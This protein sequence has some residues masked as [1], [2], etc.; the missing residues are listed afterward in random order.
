MKIQQAS[1]LISAKKYKKALIL[2]KKINS[3]K[4]QQTYSSL[5]LEG[6]CLI[7]EKKYQMAE[8]LLKQSLNMA[9]S[10]EE[11]CNTLLNLRTVCYLQEK[12]EDACTYIAELLTI[13]PSSKYAE[14]RLQLCQIAVE[15]E[16]YNAVIGFSSKL[17]G[18]DE[19]AHSAQVITVFAYAKLDK[20]DKILPLFIKIKRDINK[21]RPAQIIQLLESFS[22]TKQPTLLKELIELTSS[23][24]GHEEWFK[25]QRNIHLCESDVLKVNSPITEQPAFSI[26]KNVKIQ[27]HKRI[28]GQS[29]STIKVIE[30]LVS[31]LEEMGAK[32]HK[33]ICFV[34]C[35]GNLSIINNASVGISVPIKQIQVPLKCMPLLCDF[36]FSISE[37]QINAY[38]VK[39][40]KNLSSVP[41]MEVMIALYNK[42]NKIDY[43]Q[44][45]YPLLTLREHPEFVELLY[46]NVMG[47]L[48]LKTFK[49]LY[50]NQSWDEL[51]LQS[52]IGSREFKYS[53]SKLAN[54]KIT[55][56]N[57]YEKGFLSVI[58]F[59]N[60]KHDGASYK[61][62]N[63]DDFM[64]VIASP[65]G[66]SNEIVVQYN[67]LDPVR[68][69]LIYGFVDLN[70]AVLFSVVTNIILL[71]GLQ[72]N[73]MSLPAQAPSEVYKNVYHLR[74]YMPA[75]IRRSGNIITLSALTI[76]NNTNSDTLPQVIQAV[77]E[78]CDV[79]GVYTDKVKL[80]VEVDYI[81]KILILKNTQYWQQLSNLFKQTIESDINVLATTK[82]D[83]SNLC[84]FS[85]K[86]LSNY[87]KE[88]NLSLI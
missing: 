34:E 41:V 54:A 23:K 56:D 88:R 47:S 71:S 78:K 76:P 85:L 43:W 61:I 50:D 62:N 45:T 40:P 24:Y 83:L 81:E 7:E 4:S 67:L 70:S 77:I 72:L 75:S 26:T 28:V 80:Q 38:P 8:L 51:C 49:E 86:H 17:F 32:F 2:L 39:K 22:I 31:L 9:L 13:D 79:E 46:R 3:K 20:V 11:K 58:D 74:D 66:E 64:E 48:K 14:A 1:S 12:K 60:H 59:L 63:T 65:T 29:A 53:Q 15:N 6:V 52:F 55:T 18:L 10:T 19:Y 27:K 73:I 87:K 5:E 36:E 16:N 82:A 25:E 35:G 44:N 84:D 37:K 30:Q 42:T 69:Y 68:S 33:S 57:D 21:L